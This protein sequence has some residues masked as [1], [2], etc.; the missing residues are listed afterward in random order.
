MLHTLLADDGRGQGKNSD[1]AIHDDQERLG[2]VY[3]KEWTVQASQTEKR[4]FY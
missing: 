2:Q 3:T 4:D 1:R